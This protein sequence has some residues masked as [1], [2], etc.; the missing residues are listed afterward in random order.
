MR[1]R[2][3]TFPAGFFSRGGGKNLWCVYTKRVDA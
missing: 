3:M 2:N 1:A